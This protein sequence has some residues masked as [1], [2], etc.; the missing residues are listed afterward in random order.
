MKGFRRYPHRF[1]FVRRIFHDDAHA[2]AP[3]IVCKITHNLY[4]RMIH[5]H[6]GRNP[7]R[8]PQPER[9]NLGRRNSIA[10]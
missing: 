4:A 10:I 3:V 2:V 1:S 8:G 7:F 9:R 6:N 5:F